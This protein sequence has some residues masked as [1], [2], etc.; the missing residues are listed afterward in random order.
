MSPKVKRSNGAR[1]YSPRNNWKFS[2]KWIGPISVSWLQPWKEDHPRMR[3]F[4][5]PNLG[6]SMVFA[7]ERLW[8]GLSKWRIIYML[9][10]LDGIR[11]WSLP[12]LI[13]KTMSPHGGGH[14]NKR[15]GKTMVTLGDSLRNMLNSNLF[16]GISITF[17]GANS[18]TFWMPQMTTCGNMWGLIPN[19]CLRS[20]TCMS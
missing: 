13:W 16:Q 12:S 1:S 3:D 15:R 20:G 10:R 7:T 8:L 17:L 19:S 2:S 6:T 14:W 11:P 9:P 4:N 18:A 5:W